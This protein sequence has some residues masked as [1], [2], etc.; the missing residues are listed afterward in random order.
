M[1]FSFTVNISANSEQEA[2]Q[3]VNALMKL[4]SYLDTTQVKAV[5]DKIPQVL[6]DPTAKGVVA[7]FLGIPL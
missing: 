2:N 4:A 6:S 3:K 7:Q 5:A 1:T